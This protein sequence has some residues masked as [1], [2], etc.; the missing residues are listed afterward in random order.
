MTRSSELSPDIYGKF[1][2][3]LLEIQYAGIDGEIATPILDGRV[4]LGLSGSA[5][6]KRLHD[7]H[8][9]FRKIM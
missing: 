3:G 5:V 2:A 8:L 6:K 7:S 9:S 4:L 1:S